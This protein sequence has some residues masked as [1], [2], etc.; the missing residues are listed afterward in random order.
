MCK[1]TYVLKLTYSVKPYKEPR[2]APPAP[3]GNLLRLFGPSRYK[4]VVD[5]G[6]GGGPGAIGRPFAPLS[7]RTSL[8]GDIRDPRLSRFSLVSEFVLLSHENLLYTEGLNALAHAT[9]HRTQHTQE[10]SAKSYQIIANCLPSVGPHTV[11]SLPRP[12]SPCPRAYMR[13]RLEAPEEVVVVGGGV[14]GRAAHR[15]QDAQS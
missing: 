8:I 15:A 2:G 1:G 4:G 13:H 3:S 9:R 7:K 11:E 6:A 5:C 14:R 10:R 12:T